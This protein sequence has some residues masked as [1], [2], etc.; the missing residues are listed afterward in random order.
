MKDIYIVTGANGFL[1]NNI[2][3]RLEK[4]KNNEIR[5]LVLKNDKL[6]SLNK[7]NCKIYYGDVT[8]ID[9]LKD[10]FNINRNTKVY[11]IHCA[12]IVY[13]KSRYNPNVYNVNVNGTKN[14]V[15]KTL[16]INAKLVYINSVHAIKENNKII[17]ESTDFNSNYVKGLYAKTKALGAKFVLEQVKNN[18]LNACIIHPSGIIGPYDYGNGHLTQLIKEIINKKLFAVVKG[19]YD[20]IDVRDVVD[21]ILSACK[22][23]N[24]GECY[25]LSNKYISIKELSDIVCEIEKIKKIKIVLP[26]WIAKIAAFFL[27]FIYDIKKQTPLFTKYSL[28]TLS[29]NSNFSN[30]KSKKE[31]SFNTR[32]IYDTI[33]DTINFLKKQ[34]N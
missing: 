6:N 32:N 4:N 22:K 21:G 19:G 29:T 27:E 30:S 33:K 34:N 24:S 31:L 5:C 15:K 3:R 25:I 8:K 12:A 23:N 28:Y 14:I 13:I 18:N 17:K 7:L 1:G 11:V 10:I 2:V 9:T 20:I 26:I 16:E